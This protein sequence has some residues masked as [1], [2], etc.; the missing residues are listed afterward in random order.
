[1]NKLF[2]MAVAICV[3]VTLPALADPITTVNIDFEPQPGNSTNTYSGEGIAADAGTFWNSLGVAG[4]TNLLAS[5][6]LTVTD[7][8]VSTIYTSTYNNTGNA[9][10]KDRLIFTQN[11]GAAALTISGLN[12][13]SLYNV[14]LYAGY[15]G[16]TYSI[17]GVSKTLTGSGYNADQS[18]W[19]ENKQYVSFLGVSPAATSLTINIFDTASTF[20]SNGT[21]TG[22]TVVSGMQ[23]QQVVPVPGALVLGMLGLGAAG[24]R[25]RR[26]NA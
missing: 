17:G 4:G 7:I 11:T 10:L 6:G 2:L 15:Y 23:I 20:S 9:L 13:G 18:D 26:K 12:A 3:C 8:D 22:N 25:L 5:D 1:M 21:G 19:E 24:A 14:Y 16:Q